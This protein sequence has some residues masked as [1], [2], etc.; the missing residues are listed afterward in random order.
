MLEWYTEKARR[1]IF[2]ARYEASQYGS[3]FIRDGHLL[4]GL[5]RE[6]HLLA[7]K[8]VNSHDLPHGNRTHGGMAKRL[9][10]QVCSP[11]GPVCGSSR[12]LVDWFRADPGSRKT[13][14]HRAGMG[15]DCWKNRRCPIRRRQSRHGDPGLGSRRTTGETKSRLRSHDRHSDSGSGRLERRAGSS[16]RS[17]A[18]IPRSS[19]TLFCGC[20]Y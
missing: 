13:H 2:F 18:P 12:G 5:C 16:H 3:P 10:L 17:P 15:Q 19:L 7:R 11:W 20:R 14:L 8:L 1:V 6:D 9:T 4:L